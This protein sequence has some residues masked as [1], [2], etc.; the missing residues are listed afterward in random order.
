MEVPIVF[1]WAW[2]FFKYFR[3]PLESLELKTDLFEKLKDPS[4]IFVASSWVLLGKEQTLVDTVFSQIFPRRV[5][6]V[7]RP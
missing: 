6:W 4:Y 5:L 7:Q 2:G 1:L 3:G